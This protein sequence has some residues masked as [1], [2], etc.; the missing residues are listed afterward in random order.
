[1]YPPITTTSA[2]LSQTGSMSRNLHSVQVTVAGP[3]DRASL[4]LWYEPPAWILD[5]EPVWLPGWR[6]VPKAEGRAVGRTCDG[7]LD[8]VEIAWRSVPV[9][10]VEGLALSRGGGTDRL[11]ATATCESSCATGMANGVT[12]KR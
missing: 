11:L 4:R 3:A 12:T 5:I 10:D 7:H 9:Q 8:R 6:F 1:M 2:K